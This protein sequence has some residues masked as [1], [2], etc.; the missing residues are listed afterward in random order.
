MS[1]TE[2]L[3]VLPHLRVQNANAVSGP[4]TWGFPSMTAFVGLMHALE[5]KLAEREIDLQLDGVGV[6]CHHYETQASRAGFANTFHL[7][8]NPV[9]HKGETAAIVEEGRIHLDISL[10]FDAGGDACH[11][12]DEDRANLLETINDL[13]GGMR[14]AGGSV[15]PASMDQPRKHPT[16]LVTLSDDPDEEYQQVRKLTRQLLPGFTLVLR[17]DL[18]HS[19]WENLRQSTPETTLLDAWLDLSR[20]N[21]HAIRQ[22]TTD[23]NGN[24]IEEV[25]WQVRRPPGWI[26]PIPIGYGA[27]TETF[28]PGMIT[29]ARDTQTPFRFVESL[30]SIGEWIS[31]HRLKALNDFLWYPESD[32]Q[33]GLYYLHNEYHPRK[34][35]TA[36]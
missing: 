14:I 26:V 28:E 9:N 35:K 22:E 2:A 23:A 11:G 12:S 13:V 29:N 8:R 33:S 18:L 1:D 27:L 30:F 25:E 34:H 16:R 36:Q 21:M 31:P 24:P 17:N 32:V 3:L 15:I 19:H 4:H 10:V 7:T 20:L 6:V 5:R